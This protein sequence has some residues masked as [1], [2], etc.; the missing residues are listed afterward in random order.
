MEWGTKKDLYSVI[1]DK[2]LIYIRDKDLIYNEQI[3]IVTEQQMT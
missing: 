2:D 1:R 3:R